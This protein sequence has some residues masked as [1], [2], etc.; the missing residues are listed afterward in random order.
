MLDQSNGPRDL[1]NEYLLCGFLKYDSQI[2]EHF[3]HRE[4]RSLF[5]SLNL[6]MFIIPRQRAHGSSGLVKFPRP[7]P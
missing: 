3:S 5:L 1:Y 7:V 2:L 6:G 4:M